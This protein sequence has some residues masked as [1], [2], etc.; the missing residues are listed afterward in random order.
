MKARVEY[1]IRKTAIVESDDFEGITKALLET[2]WATGNKLLER[3]PTITSKVVLEDTIA[4]YNEGVYEIHEELVEAKRNIEKPD[5]PQ[6]WIEELKRKAIEIKKNNPL[7]DDN[8]CRSVAKIEMPD[9][10]SDG[11]MM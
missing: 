6:K 4:V 8:K 11:W 10:P 2:P 5:T 3:K 1:T 9:F 7:W